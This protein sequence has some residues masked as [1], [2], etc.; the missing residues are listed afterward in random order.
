MPKY[1]ETV[2]KEAF[3]A[4]LEEEPL[5]RITVKD[6]VQKSGLNRNS[7]YYHFH[8][9]V[10]LTE[11]IVEDTVQ[12]VIDEHPT[13]DSIDEACETA[14]A[15]IL[16]NKKAVFHI[17]HSGNRAIFEQALLRLCEYA[18]SVYVS[19]AA[20]VETLTRED[21]ALLVR[22]LKYETFGM[23][24]SWL[25]GGM[26]EEEMED[27]RRLTKLARVASHAVLTGQITL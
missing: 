24:I 13:V 27:I 16:K 7:F 19:S 8:D 23:Y 4:L 2:I 11:Q 15:L 9:I 25:D 1:A 14:L 17:Y 10:D 6:I 5:N 12:T 21:R 26:K 3:I 20:A 22:F 18:V